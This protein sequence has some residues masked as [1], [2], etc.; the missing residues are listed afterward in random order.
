M[1]VS[2][3]IDGG[4]VPGFEVRGPEV[5]F[6]VRPKQTLLNV[7]LLDVPEE[8]TMHFLFDEFGAPHVIRQGILLSED[9][10]RYSPHP[11]Q[12]TGDGKW[13][14]TVRPG[15][16]KLG[17]A[18][19]YP[20]GR[21]GFDRLVCDIAGCAYIRPRI[22]NRDFRSLPVLECG[23]DDG[24]K[25]IHYIIAGEDISES[26][27]TMV[28]DEMVRFL[29]TDKAIAEA[30]LGK[31]LVRFVPLVSLHCAARP[32]TASYDTLA[33]AGIYGASKWRDEEP[34]PEYA[35]LRDQVDQTIAE[36][37][38]G[39]LFCLHSHQAEC[40]T[41][42]MEYVRS[43]GE[44]T[45][46]PARDAAAKQALDQ[47]LEGLPSTNG[48]PKEKAWFPGLARDYLMHR[49]NVVSYRIEITTAGVTTDYFKQMGQQIL[50]NV[51]AVPDWS[52]V[53]P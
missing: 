43:G 28:T 34:P 4:V 26:A 33:G 20:Y 50:R 16:K 6:D 10:I 29:A 49:H 32:L 25:P 52:F 7:V 40:I 19:R 37:R 11:L 44:N 12:P 9:G 17:V 38:L 27:G 2:T 46:R 22:F 31:A 1:Q 48:A 39:L 8:L 45:L 23:V 41:S 36:K 14:I 13:S 30:L 3:L 18:T 15:G 21:D 47:L 51:T 24:R 5:T 35:I 53:Q 42:E